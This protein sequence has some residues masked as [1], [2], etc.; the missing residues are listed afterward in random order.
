MIERGL[1]ADGRSLPA[2]ESRAA[3]RRL[4]RALRRPHRRPLAAVSGAG[5]RTRRTRR[6]RL[7]VRGLHQ[8]ARMA[9]AP[10]ARGARSDRPLCRHLRRRHV[11]VAKAQS[12]AAAAHD[13][14]GGRPS[15]IGR[16]WS[17]IPAT[18]IDTARAAGI[19]VIAV[20][21]GYTPVPVRELN[22]DR[23]I[24]T[25]ADLPQ[26][27]FDLLGRGSARPDRTQLNRNFTLSLPYLG[28]HSK[29]P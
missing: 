9:V 20:D 21:F 27:V 15:P 5:S 8:Q 24:S 2:A 19:P 10:A 1:A 13:G 25:S 16:S 29:L 28:R 4:H 23:V 18:D 7:P 3:V 12:R 11:W 14:A 22:P 17:A 26:A 6:R